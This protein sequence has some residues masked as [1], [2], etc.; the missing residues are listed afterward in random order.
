LLGC[1]LDVKINVKLCFWC[2]ERI[3]SKLRATVVNRPGCDACADFDCH[4]NNSLLDVFIS[5]PNDFSYPKS[6]MVGSLIPPA[7]REVGG[8][9]FVMHPVEHTYLWLTA[10]VRFAFYKYHFQIHKQYLHGQP[11]QNRIRGGVMASLGWKA[12]EVESYLKS[13]GIGGGLIHQ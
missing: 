6:V 11:G 7:R 13:G 2:A 12:S 5:H 9:F 4:T 1:F 10:L 8:T 3:Q